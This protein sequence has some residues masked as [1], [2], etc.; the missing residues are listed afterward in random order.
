LIEK[1]FPP[2]PTR[3]LEICLN[4]MIVLPSFI[5]LL[6]DALR[7]IAL[8]PFL[9]VSNQ[10]PQPIYIKPGMLYRRTCGSGLTS[11]LVYFC[12]PR[13]VLSLF[14]FQ[15]AF[16]NLNI[17]R[18]AGNYIA[19]L[20]ASVGGLINFDDQVSFFSNAVAV[21]LHP[22]AVHCSAPLLQEWDTVHTM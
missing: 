17:D 22:V 16:G 4:L 11:V 15:D 1:A 3:A 10:G 19:M 20:S 18:I 9:S 13:I 21:G 8:T 2:W 12:L 6:L 7:R 5:V 14:R